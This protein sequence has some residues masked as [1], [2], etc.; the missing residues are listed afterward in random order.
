MKEHEALDLGAAGTRIFR[1][2]KC[3]LPAPATVRGARDE[4]P[5]GNR[6]ITHHCGISQP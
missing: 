3:F 5:Q 1:P 2:V 6:Q 4:S